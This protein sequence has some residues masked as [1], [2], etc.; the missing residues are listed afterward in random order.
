MQK[1]IR[2]AK[3]HE[4]PNSEIAKILNQAKPDGTGYKK[5]PGGLL[6]KDDINENTDVFTQQEYEKLKQKIDLENALKA[7]PSANPL[8]DLATM[9]VKP[10]TVKHDLSKMNV[11]Q[12]IEYMSKLDLKVN[13]KQ[14]SNDYDNMNVSP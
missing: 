8:N 5:T 7:G 10:K 12:V 6:F 11:D 13:K 14:Q 9:Q 2:S 3:K 1:V 4:D